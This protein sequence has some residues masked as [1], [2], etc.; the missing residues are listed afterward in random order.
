MN[1]VK[2]TIGIAFFCLSSYAAFAADIPQDVIGSQKFDAMKCVT[3]NTQICIN[4][5]CLTSDQRDCQ[6]NCQTM[7]QQKC[8]QQR[9]E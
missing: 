9:N 3:E 8:Q 4:S 1:Y 2:K 7:A 6:S 5:V